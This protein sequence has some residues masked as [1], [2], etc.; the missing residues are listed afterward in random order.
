MKLTWKIQTEPVAKGRPKFARTKAGFTVSYTPQKTRNAEQTLVA[1]M[2]A[3]HQPLNPLPQGAIKITMIFT[4]TRPKSA[5]QK[6]SC[7]WITRPDID[8]I[9]KTV[10][11]SMN[12]LYFRDDSQIIEAHIFKKIAG[13]SGPPFIEITMEY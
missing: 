6:K 9:F 8:N 10:G 5:P 12:G 1:L 2:I 4:R 3:Q 11:D 13:I 7:E